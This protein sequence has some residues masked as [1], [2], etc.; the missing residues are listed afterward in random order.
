M[1]A[2]QT[3]CGHAVRPSNG[4]GEGDGEGQMVCMMSWPELA[5]KSEKKEEPELRDTEDMEESE[6]Q[7][8]GGSSERAR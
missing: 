4:S 1:N 7:E 3:S 6:A 8:Q 5:D 2:R